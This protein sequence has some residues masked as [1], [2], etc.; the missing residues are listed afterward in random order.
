MI[1]KPNNVSEEKNEKDKSA[2]A[3]IGDPPRVGETITLRAAAI[4]LSTV[5]PG[6]RG[7]TIS[8]GKLLTALKTGEVRAGF[9]CSIEPLIWISIP[10]DHWMGVATDDFRAIRHVPGKRNRTGS[11]KVKLKAFIKEYIST[12]LRERANAGR[13]LSSEAVIETLNEAVARIE[14]TFEVEIS[15]G[16]WIQYLETQAAMK[17]QSSVE[18][19]PGKPGSGREA[20][21]GWKALNATL[22]AY[23]VVHNIKSS[24]DRKLESVAAAVYELTK[25]SEKTRMPTCK[26]FEKEVSRVFK[27]IEQLPAG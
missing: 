3:E 6:K 14:S 2:A 9:H 10:R 16:N 22:A 12:Y 27:L 4:A 5:S 25:K 18:I 24:E 19:V 20:Y 15:Q 11:Y 7:E 1:N 23:L 8:D 26:T 21:A 13:D 17:P